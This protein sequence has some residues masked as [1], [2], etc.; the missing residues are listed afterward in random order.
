MI[1]ETKFT[2]PR[3]ISTIPG[4]EGLPPEKSGW[5]EQVLDWVAGKAKRILAERNEEQLRLIEEELLLEETLTGQLR[6][7]TAAITD[8]ADK[9]GIA[10]RFLSGK[11]AD[12]LPV[13]LIE[14]FSRLQYG[15]FGIVLAEVSQADFCIRHKEEILAEIQRRFVTEPERDLAEFRKTNAAALKKFGL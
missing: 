6:Q 13:A 12:N 1:G 11:F 15:H 4:T 5:G 8:G 14:N 7:K 3:E 2:A 9:A 10:M